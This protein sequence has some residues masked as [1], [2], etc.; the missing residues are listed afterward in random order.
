MQSNSFRTLKHT[1]S[2]LY[3]W[4]IAFGYIEASIVIY[5][6]KIY[7]PDGFSFPIV[8]ADTDIAVVEVLRELMT[9]IIIW[10]VAELTFRSFNKKLA[11]RLDFILDIPVYLVVIVRPPVNITVPVGILLP[12]R[13]TVPVISSLSIL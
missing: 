9:L 11:G 4:G 7:Y 1:L 10:A 3:V 13:A 5:L 6:R 12:L 2:W 8:L